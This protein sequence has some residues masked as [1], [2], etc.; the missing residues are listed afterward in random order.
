[1]PR[2]KNM[3]RAA[4][5]AGSVKKRQ[6]QKD[7]K[8]YTY[9]VGRCTVGYDP[10]TGK[11][12][13]ATVSGKTQKEVQL[14]ISEKISEV[15]QGTY[16]K[17]SKITLGEWLDTWLETYVASL[18]KPYTEN[19]YRSICKNHIKPAIGAVKLERLEVTQ[20]QQL[21]N[22]LQREDGLSA[23]T[24]KNVH[25]V[26][27]RALDRAVKIKLIRDNPSDLCEL[28]KVQRKEIVPLEQEQIAALLQELHG[29]PYENV[30]LVTLFTGLRQGEVLGLTWDCV[31]FER[32]TIYV[33]KQ[34]Q[35]DQKAKG[36]YQ[37]V[38][39][40]NSRSRQIVGASSVMT[41]LK[42][43]RA[44]QAQMQLL[45]GSAWENKDNLVFTNEIGGHL[46]HVTVYKHFKAI[47]RKMGL[48]HTRFHDLRHS[49]AVAA[50][51]SGDD[52]KTVQSNLGHASAAFTLNVYAHA[53]QRMKRRS[54]E[55]MEHYIQ[56]VSG[57]A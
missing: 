21:Y 55:H 50:I 7:G 26:L 37:L 18:V 44:K 25:G 47:V 31:D 30:Y 23:K 57:N 9:W 24:I 34:L 4:N 5:G 12:K 52:I 20:I 3:G 28:P 8:T 42:R 49:Y 17:P 46:V 16:Q 27:H 10:L 41:Y 6:V 53:T 33:S 48:E 2:S 54:A 19:S 22:R 32:N 40:K 13:Q 11:Q 14:K 56:E 29:E 43:Q 36:V 39:T 38:P 15:N 35:K 45:A 51:E 1:M